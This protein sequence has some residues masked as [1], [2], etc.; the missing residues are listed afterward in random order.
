[1]GFV[2]QNGVYLQGTTYTGVESVYC[3]HYHLYNFLYDNVTP[4]YFDADL[5]SDSLLSVSSWP[6]GGPDCTV[7]ED[8]DGN[9][10]TD[11]SGTLVE[12]GVEQETFGNTF[13]APACGYYVEYENMGY[14]SLFFIM[15]SNH[16]M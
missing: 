10:S 14:S 2:S 1:M 3:Y 13:F 4:W 9:L 7:T 6:L 5:G 16:A 11:G 8:E 12:E 15:H